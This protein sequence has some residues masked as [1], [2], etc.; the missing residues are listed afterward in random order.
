M[1]LLAWNGWQEWAWREVDGFKMCR[2][3]GLR[4]V[5][6]EMEKPRISPRLLLKLLGKRSTMLGLRCPL[7]VQWR[8]GVESGAREGI[9]SGLEM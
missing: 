2:W 3:V 1:V 5:M 7:E 4:V 8:T 9:M 6:T